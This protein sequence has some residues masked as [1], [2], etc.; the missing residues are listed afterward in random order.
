MTQDTPSGRERNEA[1]RHRNSYC[2]I[3]PAVDL[4]A[5][6]QFMARHGPQL[7]SLHLQVS[8]EECLEVSGLYDDT[9]NL[10]LLIINPTQTLTFRRPLHALPY[11]GLYFPAR[12]TQEDA[13]LEL[14]RDNLRFFP[15]LEVIRLLGGF[16]N[17]GQLWVEMEM[18]R[19]CRDHRL[20]LEDYAGRRIGQ[21]MRQ[22]CLTGDA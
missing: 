14:L 13:S 11:L 9:P 15:Q 2:P 20:R 19:V 5:L 17:G 7:V 18:L 16:R 4:P 21:S 3:S 8:I 22:F 10:Q 6:S 1:F 12:C